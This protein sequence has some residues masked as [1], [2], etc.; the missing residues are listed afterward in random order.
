MSIGC[1]AFIFLFN[2]SMSF[3]TGVI[4]IKNWTRTSSNLDRFS[5][6]TEVLNT[7]TAMMMALMSLVTESG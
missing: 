2:M 7:L 6:V 4:A 5:L 1:F 3:P